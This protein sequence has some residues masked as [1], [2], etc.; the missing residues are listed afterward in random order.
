M[1]GPFKLS[2]RFVSFFMIASVMLQA[3]IG[4][5][6]PIV[7]SATDKMVA[8]LDEAIVD[9]AD[10]SA[11]WQT[12]VQDAINQLTDEAHTA[13]RSDL[14]NM[15]LRAPAAIGTEFRCDVDFVRRR[16]R[17]DLISIKARLLGLEV[18]QKEPV[19]CSVVPLA[20][21][22]SLVPQNVSLMEFY[23][24]DFDTLPVQV[25]LRNGSQDIDVSSFLDRPTHYH[26]TL[27]MGANGVQLS[28]D[29]QRFIL[30]WNGE[31]ISTIAVIQQTTPVCE[32]KHV[33]FK[34]ESIG[35][36]PPHTRGDRE[37]SGNGPDI[38]ASVKL[39]HTGDNVRVLVTMS[40]VETK[41]DYTTASGSKEFTFNYAPEA[42]YK[43]SQILSETE[44]QFSYRDDNH[45]EDTFAGG[46]PVANYRFVGDTGGDDVGQTA[47]QISFN[48]VELEL[49]QNTNCVPP[50]A[51][52]VLDA[53][54]L[55]APS[56]L[57]RLELQ[58]P[59]D[60]IIS[61]DLGNRLFPGNLF[62][63]EGLATPAP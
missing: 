14:N 30:K 47:V 62:M 58:T 32:T 59:T 12:V 24:Y 2:I 39:S 26:M 37:F 40:A 23:G 56:V 50:I 36:V 9:L 16:V 27:N 63:P 38:N 46:G 34:P 45:E 3:C 28:P 17:Q 41:S 52:R 25:L 21:D 54:N 42:G 31:E 10:E 61:P 51:V 48:Q 20:V 43:I 8:V 49:T 6:G 57:N 1:K 55:I 18:P 53:M 7:D 11:D 15:L 13:L 4:K 22:A 35:F 33:D 60:V 19:F 44:N 29:S 5:L